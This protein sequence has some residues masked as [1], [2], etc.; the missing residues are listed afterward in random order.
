MRG[1]VCRTCSTGNTRHSSQNTGCHN[2]QHTCTSSN[3]TS[4]CQAKK[5]RGRKAVCLQ[6][7]LHHASSTTNR[8]H[9]Q[10]VYTCCCHP[11][12]ISETAG[13]C[14]QASASR[15]M[16][17]AQA[18]LHS[19][20]KQPP[21]MLCTG[22]LPCLQPHPPNKRKKTQNTTKTCLSHNSPPSLNNPSQHHCIALAH[23][24]KDLQHPTIGR[25]Q[26]TPPAL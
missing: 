7:T 20:S 14:K 6:G 5:T 10:A 17:Y 11:W 26:L 16:S 8:K 3:R 23:T 19:I 21:Q 9:A 24:Q 22:T 1:V 4:C 13:R 2:N 15:C 25:L 12:P 18:N